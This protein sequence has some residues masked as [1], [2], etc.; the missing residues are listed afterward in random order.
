MSI[1]KNFLMKQMV[2]K[3]LKGM[4]QAEQDRII[5]LVEENPEIFTKIAEETQAKVKQ[6]KGQMEASIEVMKKYQT[7]LRKIMGQ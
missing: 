2:K 3:Q 4:P 5:K 1:F 7:E 6:G